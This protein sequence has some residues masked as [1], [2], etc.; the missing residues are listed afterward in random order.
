MEKVKMWGISIFL[1][2]SIAFVLVGLP[3]LYYVDPF[4]FK[5][6]EI[7]IN[8]FSQ[9][10]YQQI[11]NLLEEEGISDVVVN[12]GSEDLFRD[13][14]GFVDGS[15]NWTHLNLISKTYK[16]GV[17]RLDN[18]GFGYQLSVSNK[19][20]THFQSKLFENRCFTLEEAEL[21]IMEQV[22]MVILFSKELKRKDKLANDIAATYT[23]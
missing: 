23:K 21:V 1:G 13:K 7:P 14:I 15:F 19:E 5:H 20:I 11:V 16:K 3:Y 4:N 22:Y 12:P 6:D 18:C 9:S 17:E 10:G 8:K 2:C